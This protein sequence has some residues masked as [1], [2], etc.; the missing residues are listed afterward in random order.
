M[1]LIKSPKISPPTTAQAPPKIENFGIKI[2]H[3]IISTTKFEN[4]NGK[5]NFTFEE[6]WI[7]FPASELTKS[8]IIPN[9]SIG[10]TPTEGK[11]LLPKEYFTI[12]S[13]KK[14]KDRAKG[15]EQINKTNS[16]LT[17]IFFNFNL[18]VINNLEERGNKAIANDWGIKVIPST[19]LK[20]EPN[21]PVAT[22]P[23][24]RFNITVEVLK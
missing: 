13:G 5:N 8:S 1:L 22:G 24:I 18:S 15:N 11:Y 4:K 17:Y 6:F 20:A 23:F 9:P 7:I 12:K 19:N 10:N 16:P 14:K 2:K 21:N 3:K